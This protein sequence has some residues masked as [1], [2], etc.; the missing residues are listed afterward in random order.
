[1]VQCDVRVFGSMVRGEADY[2]GDIDLLVD[3][4]ADADGVAYFRL[5]AN[6]RPA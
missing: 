4:V 6:L 3:V 2:T 1:M 5:F